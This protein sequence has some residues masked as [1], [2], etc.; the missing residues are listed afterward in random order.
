MS[1]LWK[2]FLK[3]NRKWMEPEEDNM[4]EELK[5]CMTESENKLTS[6]NKLIDQRD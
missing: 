5:T 4:T 2:D 3:E 1:I 6:M